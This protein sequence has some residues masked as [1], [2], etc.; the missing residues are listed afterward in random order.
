MQAHQEKVTIDAIGQQSHPKRFR[1]E[2]IGT[3]T[4]PLDLAGDPRIAGP[5]GSAEH[6]IQRNRAHPEQ[7]LRKHDAPGH[8]VD[9]AIHRAQRLMAVDDGLKRRLQRGGRR[10]P[11]YSDP[12]G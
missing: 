2:A 7:H 12:D 10:D 8:T 1:L 3:A 11:G 4:D 5:V 6:R 9:L